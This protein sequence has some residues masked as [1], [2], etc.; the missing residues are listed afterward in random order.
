MAMR[1][2]YVISKHE[3]LSNTP[4]YYTGTFGNLSDG[5]YDTSIFSAIRFDTSVE[6]N[7]MIENELDNIKDN[8]LIR[9]VFK[10]EP[11][12]FDE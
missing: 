8:D 11:I 5:R 12:Y 2:R 1:M 9:A 7:K 6:A 10:I 4:M 3:W